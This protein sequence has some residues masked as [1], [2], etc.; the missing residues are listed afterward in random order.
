VTTTEKKTGA[1]LARG[2]SN[3]NR[4]T[5]PEFIAAVESRFGRIVLDLAG[6]EVLHIGWNWLGQGGMAP[7]GLIVDW[8]TLTGNLWLNPPF[9][10]LPTFAEKFGRECRNRAALSFFLCPAAVGS[11]WFQQHIVPNSYVLEL[12]DRITF[13]GEKDP[14]PKDQILAVAGFGLI[15]R[16]SWHWDKSKK[17]AYERTSKPIGESC[18]QTLRASARDAGVQP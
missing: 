2:N 17:K 16:S 8:T 5:P 9:D 1:A 18:L 12:T 10:K 13:I 15:G 4:G 7:D 11:N 3:P 14:Y 6:D